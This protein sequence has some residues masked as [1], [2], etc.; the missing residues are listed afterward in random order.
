MFSTIIV[1]Y[2]GSDLSKKALSKAIGIAQSCS[3]RL[4]VV[5]SLHNRAA[6]F[7]E[8]IFTPSEDYEKEYLN[9]TQALVDKLNTELSAIPNARA[10]LL[11]GNPASTIL[12]YAREISADLIIVGSKGQ[13]ETKELFLGSVSHNIV[14][15][16]DIPVLIIK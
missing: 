1:A 7:G 3:S 14:Q 11:I 4:E 13:S 6:M 15:H 5:H 16:A 8:L 10:T 9:R 2:D 12:N